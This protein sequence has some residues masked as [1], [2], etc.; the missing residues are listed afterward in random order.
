MLISS[1]T[2]LILDQ[3]EALAKNIFQTEIGI[4]YLAA[5]EN[6][7]LHP[8]VEAQAELKSAEWQLQQLLTEIS[9]QITHVV[10]GTKTSICGVN[11][12]CSKRKDMVQSC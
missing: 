8:S 7:R 12:N 3:A 5:Q 11:C 10:T 4:N 1:E 2:I 9:N 6:V